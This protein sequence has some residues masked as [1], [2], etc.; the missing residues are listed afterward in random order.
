MKFL[1]YLV[2]TIWGFLYN[3]SVDEK[4][5]DVLCLAMPVKAHIRQSILSCEEAM[6]IASGRHEFEELRAILQKVHDRLNSQVS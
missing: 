1:V 5:L 2:A 6:M 4:L 3:K